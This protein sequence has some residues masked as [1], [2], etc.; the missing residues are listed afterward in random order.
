M[1]GGHWKK[2]KNPPPSRVLSK[3]GGSGVVG[4]RME[5][6]TL[7]LTFRVRE[8]GCKGVVVVVVNGLKLK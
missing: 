4:A 8:G 2:S 3:G 7:R 1:C 6:M 5:E